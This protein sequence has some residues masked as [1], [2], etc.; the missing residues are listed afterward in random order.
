MGK[1]VD[2]KSEETVKKALF[3]YFLTVAF[4]LA[5]V[6]SVS[7]SIKRQSRPKYLDIL[8]DFEA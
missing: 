2:G 8:V 6:I 4:K 7:A 1:H 5:S 3:M